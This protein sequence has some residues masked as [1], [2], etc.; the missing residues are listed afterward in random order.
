MLGS[1]S[2]FGPAKHFNVLLHDP[3][4]VLR[5][6][7]HHVVAQAGNDRNIERGGEPPASLDIGGIS[8]GRDLRPKFVYRIPL[9]NRDV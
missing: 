3:V 1:I 2:A 7:H 4:E 9:S 8:V 6:L 5:C